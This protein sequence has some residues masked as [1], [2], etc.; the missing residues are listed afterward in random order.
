MPP[1]L[2]WGIING[3]KPECSRYTPIMLQKLR[4]HLV[5]SKELESF[6]V[7]NKER[8]QSS[9]SSNKI[10]LFEIQ[11]N[12]P[13]YIGY[14]NFAA[15]FARRGYQLIAYKPINDINLYSR[16]KFH[17]LSKLSI[18]NGINFPFRIM[19][20]MGIDRFIIPPICI[21]HN[22]FAVLK[23]YKDYVRLSKS[24]KL[25]F[26][27]DEV[28]IGDLFY[29]WHLR[30]RGTATIAGNSLALFYDFYIFVNTYLFWQ[31]FFRKN[32]IESVL[33][34]HGVYAQGLVARIGIKFG[35][36]TFLVGADRVY[37]LTELEHFPDS[38]FKYYDP[39]KLYQFGYSIDYERAD[40]AIKKLISG[41]Q[42]V[43][44]A[45][46]YVSGFKGSRNEDVIKA[47]KSN[48]NILIAAHC[49]SDAPHA[50]GD[51]LFPDFFEWL[52]HL[53]RMSSSYDYNWYVKGHPG[54]F[55]SDSI[56]FKEIVKE[57]PKINVVSSEY[58][59]IEL[60]KQGI[61]VV[62]TV[63]G[64]IAFEAAYHNILVINASVVAPHINYSF[65]L[66]PKSIDE[67]N[68]Y[69]QELPKIIENFKINREEVLHFY[70]LHHLRK[71]AN[72]YF[73]E[74][75]EE[76]LRSGISYTGIFSS[77][78]ILGYWVEKVYDRSKFE[79]VVNRYERFFESEDYFLGA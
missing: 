27:L 9:F 79:G 7:F 35:A 76:V 55:K 4:R 53:G 67:Y 44:N 30:K 31:D 3:G 57:F 17:L 74:K 19:K 51:Q 62:L 21:W 29:D 69:I 1:G 52:N 65:S 77:P 26:S 37:R 13:A 41:A 22:L 15:M 6:I 2:Q 11:I 61:N 59:N 64:T 18:D 8:I 39:R 46:A 33:V 58:S 75:Y 28:R 32:E 71:K 36:S 54:F 25:H 66:C 42:D 24:E 60:F 14:S 38:E 47:A 72:V 50:Y 56:H 48:V 68:R 49:F 45:H 34:S 12:F 40:K 5:R 10:V 43:D 16:L 20:S 63:H 78:T 23:L 70:D 73:D